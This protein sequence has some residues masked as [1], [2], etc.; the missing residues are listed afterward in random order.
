MSVPSDVQTG[1][2]LV[3]KASGEPMMA[4]YSSNGKLLGA[5]D[6]SKITELQDGASDD[7]NGADAPPDT[8]PADLAPAPSGTV[9]M[10]PAVPGTVTKST[11]EVV[12]AA[13]EQ[14]VKEVADAKDAEYA[15]VVKSLED[16]VAALEAPA[17]SRVL[18]NGALP[19][20]HLLRGMDQGAGTVDVAKATE[21]RRKLD[22]APDATAREAIAKEMNAEAVLAWQQLRDSRY[23]PAPQEN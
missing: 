19:P 22:S 9:G 10:A 4:V 5:V 20:T 13:I 12:K 3:T 7:D 15:S 18:S 16:R 1:N 21:L 23:Q 14:A 8:P 2:G 6:P 17:P 11:D